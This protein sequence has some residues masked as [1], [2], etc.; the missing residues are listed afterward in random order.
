MRP[1]P[2][3]IKALAC[4]TAHCGAAGSARAGNDVSSGCSAPAVLRSL[5]AAA[6]A[7]FVILRRTP[8]AA[9]RNPIVALS[10]G[11]D[12]TILELMPPAL[13]ASAV[14]DGAA[15]V[16]LAAFQSVVDAQRR[17]QPGADAEAGF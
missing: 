14:A 6:V 5:I 9:E 17:L 16:A 11:E 13:G 4:M 2:L 15:D 1:G 3:M 7:E 10:L 8:L 12:E